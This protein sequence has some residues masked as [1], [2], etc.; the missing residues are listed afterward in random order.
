VCESGL[1]ADRI[2]EMD[3]RRSLNGLCLHQNGAF[4]AL[5]PVILFLKRRI[6]PTPRPNSPPSACR[7]ARS[8]TGDPSRRPLRGIFR[9]MERITGQNPMIDT[10]RDSSSL[11]RIAAHLHGSP[12]AFPR[13]RHGGGGGWGG[14]G[15]RE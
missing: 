10:I 5:R 13:H 11:P 15:A 3:I 7:P 2:G 12:T 4:I 6:P 9:E 1:R 14:A 8:P